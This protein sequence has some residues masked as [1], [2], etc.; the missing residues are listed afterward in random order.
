[1]TCLLSLKN[2]SSEYKKLSVTQEILCR[3]AIVKTLCQVEDVTY[4]SFLVDGQ[5]LKDSLDKPIGFMTAE[6]FID[7]TGCFERERRLVQIIPK[8]KQILRLSHRAAATGA[9]GSWS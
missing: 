4:V 5:P 7:N 1:M 3:A 6:D 9:C 8:L 2:I